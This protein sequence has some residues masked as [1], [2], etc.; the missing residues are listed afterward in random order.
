MGEDPWDVACP[1]HLVACPVPLVACPVRL[2]ASP[3]RLVACPVHPEASQACP[4]VAWS[5]VEAASVRAL[6]LAVALVLV[7]FQACLAAQAW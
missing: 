4:L 6:D 7:A 5:L 2:V 3:V 1:V